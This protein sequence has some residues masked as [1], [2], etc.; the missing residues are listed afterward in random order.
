MWAAMQLMWACGTMTCVLRVTSTTHLPTSEGWTAELAEGLWF[1]VSATGIESTRVDPTR[2]ET[3]CLNHSATPPL[4]L[5]GT[6][7]LFF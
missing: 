4:Y 2:F 7:L 5:N 1:V 3:L 6:L